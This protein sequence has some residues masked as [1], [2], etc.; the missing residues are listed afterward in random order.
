MLYLCIPFSGFLGPFNIGGFSITN[1]WGCVTFSATLRGEPFQSQ[2]VGAEQQCGV[3]PPPP[4]AREKVKI[5]FLRGR[6]DFDVFKNRQNLETKGK[7]PSESAK[8][9]FDVP[10]DR[11]APPGPLRGPP[12][13]SGAPLRGPPGS[14]GAPPG[15]LRGPVVSSYHPKDVPPRIPTVL[16]RSVHVD[17]GLFI[18]R[19]SLFS[20]CSVYRRLAPPDPK[21]LLPPLVGKPCRFLNILAWR[22]QNTAL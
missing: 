10:K 1:P 2:K 16:V 21:A 19:W 13:P 15:P 7:T 6:S 3:T 5:R 4:Y 9:D 20:S 22:P 17:P 11:R 12:G 14:S 18:I 8:S